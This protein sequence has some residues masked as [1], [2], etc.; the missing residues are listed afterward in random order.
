VQTMQ[1]LG[2]GKNFSK[3]EHI[4]LDS[5]NISSGRCGG[6]VDD[7]LSLASNTHVLSPEGKPQNAPSKAA[8]NSTSGNTRDNLTK[9]E[10]SF[11]RL[12]DEC[13]YYIAARLK[14]FPVPLYIQ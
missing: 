6:D 4:F 7:D 12:I 10:N 13:Y 2:M 3:G 14:E 11:Q 1:A 9:D 5:D 8:P